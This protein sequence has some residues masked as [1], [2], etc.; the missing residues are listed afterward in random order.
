M[1]EQSLDINEIKKLLPHRY[2]FLL[3]DRVLSWEKDKSI[4]ALKNVSINEPHFPGHFPNFPIMPGVLIIEAFAQASGILMQLSQSGEFRKD[5]KMYL[6]GVSKARFKKPV[7]PGDT[8][9]LK[10]NLLRL[11]RQTA[12]LECIA[13]VKDDVV[14]KAELLTVLDNS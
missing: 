1:T 6:A 8:L 10:S 14:C 12:Q 9:I 13:K 7:V 5:S 4:T 2:P 3:V 11:H